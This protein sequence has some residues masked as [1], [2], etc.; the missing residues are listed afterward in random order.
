MFYVSVSLYYYAIP[1]V[2]SQTKKTIY[3][4]YTFFKTLANCKDKPELADYF[5][6]SQERTPEA[7]AVSLRTLGTTGMS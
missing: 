6:Q 1:D 2:H 7:C 3:N 4:V 5:R